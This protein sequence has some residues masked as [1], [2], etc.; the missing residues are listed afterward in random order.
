M[1]PQPS[2][3]L[4]INALPGDLKIA[5]LT[6]DSR[7]VRPGFLFAALPGTTADGRAFIGQALQSG[8]GAILAPVGTT[9]P[10][11]STARLIVDENPRR[12]L[13]LM[14]AAFYGQ[15][16]ATMVAV[17]G[18]NGK[19]STADFSRQI[20]TGMGK[21]AASIGTLGIIAPGWDNQGGLTTPDPE[22]LHANLARLAGLGIEYGCIEASSHGLTQYRLD[23]VALKAAAFTN[24]TRD[25]LDYH[26]SMEHYGQAKQRLFSELLPTDGVA[27]INADSDHSQD[28]IA[29][30]QSRKLRV[31][32]FGRKGADIRLN[33]SVPVAQGQ[34]LTLTVLG[35]TVELQLPLAGTFQAWNALAALGL[36]IATGSDQTAA[37]AQISTLT[38][39]PGRL[40]KVAQRTSGASIYVDYAHTP[41]ALETV[42]AALRPHVTDSG[43]LICLFGCGGDRDAGKRPQ[44]GAIA[45][46]KA[47]MVFVTD[48]NPRSEDAT[49]IRRAIL[50]ACPDAI[51]IGERSSA[52]R[53]AV[54]TLRQGDV[55]VLAGK[56]HERG[57]IVGSTILPFDDAEEAQKAVAEIDMITRRQ[58]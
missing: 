41:D 42:L 18:T 37:A 17:T 31:L 5:G 22:T 47:D 38:G 51:E 7:K 33:R 44:M 55:L 6:C 30:A 40:Q 49:L 54:S 32:T 16:P 10:A 39:V 24:L 19:T 23:G 9:L 25:H 28:F 50:A 15:Q 56:G 29:V 45:A 21:K 3:Y 35:Q 58:A 14:A 8:A 12:R 52:I 11:A 2:E 20:W 36:V 13:S 48:D 1:L 26:G 46:Q 34:D 43:R 57:Q 4:K 53:E 27:V